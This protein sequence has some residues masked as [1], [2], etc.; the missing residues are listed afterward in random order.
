M[1]DEGYSY[2]EIAVELGFANHSSVIKR[3]KSIKK[4]Y[5]SYMEAWAAQVWKDGR[6][7]LCPET[8]RKDK[9]YP[10]RTR[11]HWKKTWRFSLSHDACA[12]TWYQKN[13]PQAVQQLLRRQLYPSRQRRRSHLSA[14]ALCFCLLS[15][16]SEC[17]PERSGGRHTWGRDI[18]IRHQ[19]TLCGMRQNLL[20]KRQSCEILCCM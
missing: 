16:L 14:N 5:Q 20:C 9:N 12:A 19:K 1:R 4:K 17:S 3:M 10:K 7:F 8:E 11:T 2:M 6:G 15:I 18:Y 13:H